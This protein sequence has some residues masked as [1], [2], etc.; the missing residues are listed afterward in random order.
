[1]SIELIKTTQKSSK[2]LLTVCPDKKIS[3]IYLNH[4]KGCNSWFSRKA[5]SI[6]FISKHTQGGANLVPV[7]VPEICCLICPLNSKYLFF[8]TKSVI[9]ISSLVGIV[10]C[11]L[12]STTSLWAF[13]PVSCD[14]LGYKPTTPAV[15]KI[16]FSGIEPK[17]RA[18]FINSYESL[19]YHHPFYI[20]GFMW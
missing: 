1:M 14:M 13:N 11:F 19:M 5:V 10:C 18:F 16:A 20:K 7:A 9:L 12:L 6:L 3:S 2:F 8:R 15:A 4:A 17:F